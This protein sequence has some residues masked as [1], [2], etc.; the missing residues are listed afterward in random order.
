MTC[1]KDAMESNG[2]NTWDFFFKNPKPIPDNSGSRISERWDH[3]DSVQTPKVVQCAVKVEDCCPEFT[4]HKE[5]L[6]IGQSY[7]CI[8][9]SSSKENVILGEVLFPPHSLCGS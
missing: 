8:S 3:K 1:G 6:R 2:R 7:S 5:L 9:K 4:E